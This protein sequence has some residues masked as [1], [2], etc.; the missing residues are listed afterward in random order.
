M[1][2][3]SLALVDDPT[4]PFP[5]LAVVGSVAGPRACTAWCD[6]G[7]VSQRWHDRAVDDNGEARSLHDPADL[8]RV[9]S[10]VLDRVG[11]DAVGLEYRLVGTASAL[12]QGVRLPVGDIDI[13]LARR[14]DVDTFATALSGFLC[15]DPAAWMPDARQYFARFAIDETKVELSTVEASMDIGTH[16]CIG[17]GP[18]RHYVRI[19]IGRHVVPVVSLELRLVTELVRNRPDRYTPL[20]EHLRLNG[21]DLQLVQQAMRERRL[22]PGRQ[23]RVLDQLHNQ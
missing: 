20:I 9:L 16:E 22:D 2:T 23:A 11:P 21:A 7:F 19:S 12:A 17:S 5:G 8:H 1:R 3:L 14:G 15:L 10:L 13:L 6:A 4:G 18:W